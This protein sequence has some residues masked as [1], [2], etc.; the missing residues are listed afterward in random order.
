MLWTVEERELFG[1]AFSIHELELFALA[2]TLI[3]YAL[4]MRGTIVI[5]LT[6]SASSRDTINSTKARTNAP[7]AILR[8]MF[9]SA[10][11]SDICIARNA[12]HVKG[13][14]NL[15]SDCSSRDGAIAAGELT[16]TACA[17]VKV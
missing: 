16:K 4:H 8:L 1:E 12:E 3:I 9:E 15:I 11:E 2:Y 10:V 5:M 13:K 6:D 17:N 14:D 7:A